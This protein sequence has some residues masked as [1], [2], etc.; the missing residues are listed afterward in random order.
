M[1]FQSAH[2][3]DAKAESAFDEITL[4]F[5]RHAV[6]VSSEPGGVRLLIESDA[7]FSL[8]DIGRLLLLNAKYR[9][10]DLVLRVSVSP[11][12]FQ[13]LQ[14]LGIERIVWIDEA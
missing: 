3:F 12:L 11:N 2:S 1:A 10:N 13:Q 4:L 8:T 6:A 5:P 14:S 7:P 9:D